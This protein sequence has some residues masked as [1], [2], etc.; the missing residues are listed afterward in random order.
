LRPELE[1]SPFSFLCN[2]IK[3]YYSMGML[4]IL[5]SHVKGWHPIFTFKCSGFLYS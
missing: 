5:M 2:R 1:S 3:S 4:Q